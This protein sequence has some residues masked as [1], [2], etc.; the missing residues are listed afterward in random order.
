M[1]KRILARLGLLIVVLFGVTVLSFF[2]TN[3]SPVDASEALAVRRYNRP[4][5]PQV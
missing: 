1:S 5:A 2:Y 4:T 3:L